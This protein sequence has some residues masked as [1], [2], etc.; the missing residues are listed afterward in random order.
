MTDPLTKPVTADEKEILAL[1]ERGARRCAM[2][3]V[4]EFARSTMLTS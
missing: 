2:G 3:I 1:V 4:R